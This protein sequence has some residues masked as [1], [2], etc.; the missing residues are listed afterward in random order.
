MEPRDFYLVAELRYV[1]QRSRPLNSKGKLR[2]VQCA[3]L[4]IHELVREGKLTLGKRGVLF[5]TVW[6]EVVGGPDAQ[7]LVLEFPIKSV[8]GE[9][10]DPVQQVISCY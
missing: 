4:D 3:R 6:F 7:R 5:G 10:L 2:E 8:S 1:D 9:W